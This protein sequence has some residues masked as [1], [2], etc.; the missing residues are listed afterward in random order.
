VFSPDVIQSIFPTPAIL[1]ASTAA[2]DPLTSYLHKRLLSLESS[3]LFCWIRFAVA[4]VRPP[5]AV[6]QAMGARMATA[7]GDAAAMKSQGPAQ[8]TGSSSGST[9]HGFG[10]VYVGPPASNIRTT[11]TPV[12]SAASGPPS[13]LSGASPVTPSTGALSLLASRLRTV[14][15]R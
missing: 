2:G 13:K 11:P 14:W 10:V 15:P 1:A 4:L 6:M 7:T 9:G 5:P 8:A 12:A 3:L